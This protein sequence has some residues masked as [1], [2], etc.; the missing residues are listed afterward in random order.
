MRFSYV[1]GYLA[2]LSVGAVL[3]LPAPHHQNTPLTAQTGDAVAHSLPLSVPHQSP[4]VIEAETT[5]L[6]T[7]LTTS[8]SPKLRKRHLVDTAATVDEH[9]MQMRMQHAQVETNKEASEKHGQ[10]A[11]KAMKAWEAEF[12]ANGHS[13]TPKAKLLYEEHTLNKHLEKHY[14]EL[15]KAAESGKSYHASRKA[16]QEIRDSY[17]DRNL[18][19]HEQVRIDQHEAEAAGHQTSYNM[20]TDLAHKACLDPASGGC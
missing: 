11:A 16:A 13:N 10:K 14:D 6:T 2:T 18:P 20:H 1:F 9:K 8:S 5:G 15:S 7:S 12:Q 4:S 17:A 3:A 19:A